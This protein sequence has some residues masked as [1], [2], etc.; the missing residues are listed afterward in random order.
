MT[1]AAL[2]IALFLAPGMA[3]PGIDQGLEL[4]SPRSFWPDE[5]GTVLTFKGTQR[6]HDAVVVR[7][8]S[9]TQEFLGLAVIDGIEVQETHERL[10]V[11]QAGEKY[12]V[13]SRWFQVVDDD[14]IRVV[15]FQMED[16]NEPTIFD[17]GGEIVLRRPLEEGEEWQNTSTEMFLLAQDDEVKDFRSRC[18]IVGTDQ[19]I[20]VAAGEFAGCLVTRSVG[21][22][23]GTFQVF[24]A[25]GRPQA[26]YIEHSVERAFAPGLGWIRTVKRERAVPATHPHRTLAHVVYRSELFRIDKKQDSSSKSLSGD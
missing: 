8:I 11:V 15:G 24:D 9:Y 5:P 22:T 7:E 13:E 16:Q 14:L 25:E 12:R 23:E 3:A 2:A 17:D 19:V 26:A 10:E 1:I 4:L 6:Y 20:R 21:M 18:R